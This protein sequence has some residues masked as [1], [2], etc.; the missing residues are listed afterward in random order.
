MSDRSRHSD[1]LK[2]RVLGCMVG[3]AVGDALGYPVE[4]WN[5]DTILNEYGRN[6]ITRYKL[7]RNGKALISDDTQMTLFTAA[8]LLIGMTRG[9]MRGIMGR[10]DTYCEKTYGDW[11]KTQTLTCRP[12]DEP[13]YSWLMDVRELYSRRAPGN[14]CLEAIRSLMDHEA[15]SNNSCGCGGVMRTAPVALIC[16]VHRYADG[17]VSYADMV[18]AETARI[19]HKHPLGF[20]PSAV[21][22]HLLTDIL[23]GEVVGRDR[24]A[25]AARQA[26]DV[27]PEITSEEDKSKTYLELWPKYVKRMQD[28]VMKAI[29]MAQSDIPDESAIR[30]IG[31]G[32]TGHESLAIALYSAIKHADNFE[33][34]VVSA[35]NHSGDSD[36]SGAICGNILGCL[37][38]RSRIPE[39]YTDKLELIDVI[40]EIANDLYTGCIISEYDPCDTPEKQRWERKYVDMKWK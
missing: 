36:S 7:G 40:E 38:G 3:G 9:Y 32:W 26:I 2:D 5:Y 27:L 31:E 33:D 6:G 4:F 16:H 1:E 18:A 29:D 39:Y 22:N 20:L 8:G 34:A 10:L 15:A 25:H 17:N 13:C 37:L 14:T 21:L 24:L 30:Q 11:L 19:T 28:I 35:V 12:E 23:A